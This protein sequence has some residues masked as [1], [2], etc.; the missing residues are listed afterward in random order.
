QQAKEGH[1]CW[2]PLSPFNLIVPPGV[3][4]EKYFPWE[5]TVIPTPVE[6]IKERYGQ[7]AADVKED[8][9]I[10]SILGMEAQSTATS[11]PTGW[12]IG[13]SRRTRLRDH[14][15]LFTYYE[16]PT[17]QWPTGRTIVFVNNRMKLLEVRDGAGGQPG[18]PY[19]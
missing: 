11:S 19:Q 8:P 16:Q 3:V 1:I 18:L 4:H 10:G 17:S 5:C 14:A 9:D 12:M 13:E 2:R 7:V 6:E 15:W